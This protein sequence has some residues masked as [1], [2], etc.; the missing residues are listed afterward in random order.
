MIDVWSCSIDKY[1]FSLW[2][3]ISSNQEQFIQFL[4]REPAPSASSQP[5]PLGVPGG[6]SAQGVHIRVTPQEKEAIDRVSRFTLYITNYR[7]CCLLTLFCL[8][9]FFI[10][11]FK[12]IANMVYSDCSLTI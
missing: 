11:V 6:S 2:Q 4:N 12:S 9:I 5:M 7:Y 3:L 1:L 8:F 10:S